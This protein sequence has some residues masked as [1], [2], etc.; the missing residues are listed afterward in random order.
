MD[1]LET[2]AVWAAGELLR[3]SGDFHRYVRTRDL[4]KQ[5][6]IVFRHCLRM[7]VLCEEFAKTPPA[8]VWPEEWQR[9]FQDIAAQLT[10]S[11]RAVDPDSTDE[12][13][14]HLADDL[15]EPKTPGAAEVLSKPEDATA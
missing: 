11:C 7:I 9:E 6:G 13:V 8:A 2:T 12:V 14:E 3:F 5:E 1:D 10:E 15:E 4:T